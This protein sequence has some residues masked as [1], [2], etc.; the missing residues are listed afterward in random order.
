MGKLL[1][2][3]LIALAGYWYANTYGVWV[4]VPPFTPVG[5][6]N[7]TGERAYEIKVLGLEDG[8]R[9]QVSGD[10]SEGQLRVWIGQ[11]GRP[12]TKVRVYE[13]RF[14]ALVK[15]KLEPGVYFVHFALRRAKGWVR[16]DWL[17][18]RFAPSPL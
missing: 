12:L 10:L 14:E 4:G 11:E 15:E 17:S 2:L 9:I 6:W 13:G 1:F 7:Y 3:A 5:V 18:V 16:L 8:I